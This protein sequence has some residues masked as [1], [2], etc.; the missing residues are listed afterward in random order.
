MKQNKYQIDMCNGPLA[1]KMIRFALPLMAASIIQLMFNAADVVVVGKF[2]GDAS[3]AAVTST[4]SLINLLIGL[5]SGLGVG[6]N[7]LVAQALGSG[8]RRNVSSVVHTS[9]VLALV[10][11]GI[12][13]VIG[14][15][16]APLLLQMMGSPEIRS[17]K[18][19]DH[20]ALSQTLPS[21]L[22]STTMGVRVL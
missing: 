10:C 1:G 12:L 16:F 13:T 6:V 18:R 2:A 9:V 21:S 19:S 22:P 3:Q 14:E 8:D 15:L 4:S 20:G 7:V 17:M 5:F 11:G